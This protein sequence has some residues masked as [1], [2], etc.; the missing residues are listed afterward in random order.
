MKTKPRLPPGHS[1]LR[2]LTLTT[3]GAAPFGIFAPPHALAQ[4]LP[5]R[6][7]KAKSPKPATV[8]QFS[9]LP[10]LSLGFYDGGLTFGEVLKKGDFGLGTVDALDGEVVILGGKAWQVRSDGQ[11]VKLAPAVTTPFAIV[12]RFKPDLA[13]TLTQ[14]TDYAALRQTLDRFLPSANLPYAFSIQGTFSSIKTRSVPRQTKPYPPLAQVTKTQTVWEWQNVKG[15]LV[16]FRFPAYLGDVNL[17]DYHFHFLADDKSRGGHLLDCQLQSGQIQVQTLRHF[18]MLLPH[19]GDFDAL[20]LK[21]DQKAALK[22]A[23]TGK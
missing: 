15:T 20:D 16:G 22:Q 14:P 8:F 6:E 7:A 3:I 18:D 11:I 9:T 13:Q 19:S 10:A 5:Q 21:T 17:P 2:A 12:T 1:L 23:E 4:E